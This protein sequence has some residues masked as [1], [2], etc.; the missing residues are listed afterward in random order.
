MVHLQCPRC[1]FE[2]NM[3]VAIETAFGCKLHPKHPLRVLNEKLV[4]QNKKF[5]HS[6]SV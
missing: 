6:T 1:N 5:L 2:N 4:F 3:V